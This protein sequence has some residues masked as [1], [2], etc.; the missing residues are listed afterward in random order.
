MPN[1]CGRSALIEFS[2]LRQS[3]AED[4]MSSGLFP[5]LERRDALRFSSLVCSPVRLSVEPSYVHAVKA[6][7]KL[8]CTNCTG[9]AALVGLI[10]PFHVLTTRRDG[11]YTFREECGPQVQVLNRSFLLCWKSQFP[12]PMASWSDFIQRVSRSGSPTLDQSQLSVL[13]R[14]LDFLRA[15]C[16]WSML[17]GRNGPGAVAGGEKGPEKWFFD[18]HPRRTP[19]D[20]YRLNPRHVVED[21]WCTPIKFGITR[22]LQVPKD[23]RGPRFISC[24]PL[25]Y[26]HAQFA[27]KDWLERQILNRYSDYLDPYDTSKHTVFLRD[28]SF[29]TIDLKDASDMVS[30]R[31]VWSVFPRDI[32][33]M[34]FS[35]R[36][37][38]VSVDGNVIPLRTFAPMGSSLCFDIM[39]CIIVAALRSLT[40]ASLMGFHQF[41]DDGI[42][43]RGAYYPTLLVLAQLGLRVNTT[44]CCGPNSRFRE[45]CGEE[46][47][48]DMNDRIDI[49][50]IYLRDVTKNR[51]AATS[52]L[53]A[54]QR[55]AAVGF[56][57]TADV[58]DSASSSLK[59]ERPREWRWNTQLQR[60]EIRTMRIAPLPP[61]TEELDGYPG[62][63]RWFSAQSE[64]HLLDCMAPRTRVVEGWF[65]PS[66]ENVVL[67]RPLRWPTEARRTDPRKDTINGEPLKAFK[68]RLLASAGECNPEGDIVNVAGGSVT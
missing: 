50:P 55:L 59:V 45:S 39:Q 35:V 68:M 7:R 10:A 2:A 16:N 6:W 28:R 58:L 4:L 48:W 67:P 66:D 37:T 57:A 64:D 63:Y 43:G 33:E 47:F 49:R 23:A 60:M 53:L 27:V 54:S 42:V 19:M 30:R 61:E 21:P 3:L 1:Q 9:D 29:C 51:K 62:L 36:S 20:F 13:R 14:E 65:D 34:L 5:N 22:A 17:R 44:K 32:A 24:E 31:L 25:A 26:Q 8:L 46:W 11:L 41:G 15:P 12:S 40:N 38:F 56:N 52:L 18:S